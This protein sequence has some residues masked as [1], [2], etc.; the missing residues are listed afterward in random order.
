MA[1]TKSLYQ[2]NHENGQPTAEMFKKNCHTKILPQYYTHFSNL[3]A[4]KLELSKISGSKCELVLGEM[5]GR[6]Q[7]RQRVVGGKTV[8]EL[9]PSLQKLVAKVRS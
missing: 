2:V 3:K 7:W 5:G 4:G 1:H 9:Q 8:P 6:R